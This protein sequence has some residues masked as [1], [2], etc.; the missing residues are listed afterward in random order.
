MARLK[1]GII[2]G[3][4]AQILLNQSFAIV[5]EHL[6]DFWM[7]DGTEDEMGEGG[8]RAFGFLNCC[9]DYVGR[10]LE[11]LWLKRGTDIIYGRCSFNYV[12]AMFGVIEVGPEDFNACIW[13]P[14]SQF[15]G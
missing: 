15:I 7:D 11:L 6:T 1:N 2:Q 13:V 9:I 12:P 3:R 5:V 14:G 10:I 4:L 8:I